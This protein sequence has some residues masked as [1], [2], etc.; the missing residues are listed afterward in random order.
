MIK[1]LQ[2]TLFAEQSLNVYK[3]YD[4]AIEHKPFLHQKPFL[5]W[6]KQLLADHQITEFYLV[7]EFGMLDFFMVS[8]TEE[9]RDSSVD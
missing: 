1:E 9:N 5:N 7:T 8:E 6:F 3:L 4:N 2:F